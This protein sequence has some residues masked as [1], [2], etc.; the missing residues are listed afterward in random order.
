M[1]RNKIIKSYPANAAGLSLTTIVT[2]IPLLMSL[3][4]RPTFLSAPLHK[5]NSRIPCV[6][7]AR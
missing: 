7:C 4:R 3:T 1:E 6:T 2:N 5:I